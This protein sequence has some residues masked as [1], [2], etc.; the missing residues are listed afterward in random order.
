MEYITLAFSIVSSILSTI[1]LILLLKNKKTG[2]VSLGDAELKKIRNSVNESVES[3]SNTVSLL[4]AEKN[5][6]LMENV[7]KRLMI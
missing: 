2:D 4:V 7:N 3:L 6:S 5:S 1:V